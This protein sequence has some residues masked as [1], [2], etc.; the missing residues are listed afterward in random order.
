MKVL[1]KCVAGSHLFGTNT[2][3]SDKDYKGVYIPDADS[4]LS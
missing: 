2:E 3:N 1:V 4:I